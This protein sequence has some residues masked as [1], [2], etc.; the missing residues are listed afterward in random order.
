MCYELW[1]EGFEVKFHPFLTLALVG[2]EGA[3]KAGLDTV[4]NSEMPAPYW[5]LTVVIWPLT[6]PLSYPSTNSWDSIVSRE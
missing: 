4:A 3:L 1:Q 5:E 2:S 6:L